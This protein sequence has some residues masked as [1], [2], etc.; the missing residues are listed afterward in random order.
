MVPTDELRQHSPRS[1]VFRSLV[2]GGALL[3]AVAA[4]AF[5]VLTPAP[6]RPAGPTP[7]PDFE[8]PLLSGGSLSSDDLRGAPVVLNLWA[9]W[10]IP[11][12]EEAPLLEKAWDDYKDQGVK[13]IGVNVKDSTVDAKAFV[14][15]F[16]VSYPIV[17]DEQKELLEKL[18]EK[19]L[20]QV[21][22]LPQ[23][24]FIDR[25]WKLVREES[26]EAAA[27]G[28]GTVVLGAISR[29]DLNTGIEQL[30]DRRKTGE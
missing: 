1:R 25:S 24:L 18:L 26:G 8:L 29:E 17:V 14:R 5:G 21:D 13:I 22:G 28:P 7:V 10:C 6:D 3:L 23:T 12:R 4:V 2:I 30:L 27:S 11:C 20:L 9:S 16:N 15:K 19:R